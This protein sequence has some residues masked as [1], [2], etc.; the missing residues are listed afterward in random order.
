MARDWGA[1]DFLT[2]LTFAALN[3]HKKLFG[4]AGDWRSIQ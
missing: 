4:L 1:T 3:G 2:M